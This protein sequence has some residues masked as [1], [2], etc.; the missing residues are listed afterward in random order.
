MKIK[1]IKDWFSRMNIRI[2]IFFCQDEK[3][4][5]DLWIAYALHTSEGRRMLGNA[6]IDPIKKLI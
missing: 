6:M 4:K 3:F 2:K 5:K 1:Y